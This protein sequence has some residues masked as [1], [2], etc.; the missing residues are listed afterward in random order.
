MKTIS[1]LLPI[2]YCSTFTPMFLRWYIFVFIHLNI[3]AKVL[4]L[5]TTLHSYRSIQL[6]ISY[7]PSNATIFPRYYSD[8]KITP[9]KFINHRH[10][11]IRQPS[12]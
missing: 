5:H 8:L 9:T 1:A 12:T 3:F 11:H 4:L 2:Y 7:D 10:L 6:M